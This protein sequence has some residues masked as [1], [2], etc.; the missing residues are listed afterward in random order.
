[1]YNGQTRKNETSRKYSMKRFWQIW[2]HALGSFDAEDGYNPRN[3]NAIAIIRTSIVLINM[4]CGILI[5]IN[6]L[7]AW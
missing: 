6:I 7:K 5:M 2:K 3:E 4:L 1:M